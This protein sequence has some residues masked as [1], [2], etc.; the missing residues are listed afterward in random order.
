[1]AGTATR[2]NR[3][4]DREFLQDFLQWKLD[5]FEQYALR[6]EELLK[7]EQENLKATHESRVSEMSEQEKL[8]ELDYQSVDES[9]LFDTFPSVLRGSLL[10]FL[11]GFLENELQV[12]C[13]HLRDTHKFELSPSDLRGKGIVLYQTYF[14]KVAGLSFPDQTPTWREILFLNDVRNHIVHNGG[15]V[16]DEKLRTAI[17]QSEYVSLTPQSTL[18]LSGELGKHVVVVMRAFVADL[19]GALDPGLAVRSV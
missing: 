8:M 13:S 16:K 4:L 12:L 7:E 2:P 10:M 17:R 6:F 9:K 19:F 11:I 18:V 14:K 3:Q 15:V 5:E 1:M